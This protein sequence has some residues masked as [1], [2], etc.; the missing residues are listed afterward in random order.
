MATGSKVLTGKTANGGLKS[1]LIFFP[2]GPIGK[3]AKTL[4]MPVSA[5]VG[6]V[7]FLK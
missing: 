2:G 5:T 6:I 1:D 4:Q 3:K 7:W